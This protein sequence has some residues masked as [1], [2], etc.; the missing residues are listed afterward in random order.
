MNFSE[1]KTYDW[2]FN[3]FTFNRLIDKLFYGAPLTDEQLSYAAEII[4]HSFHNSGNGDLIKGYKLCSYYRGNKKIFSFI[5]DDK[6]H[7]LDIE[8]MK[9]L[10]CLLN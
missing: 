8:E 7:R 10:R 4:Y 5:K 2:N 9:N 1:Y 3:R 6:G